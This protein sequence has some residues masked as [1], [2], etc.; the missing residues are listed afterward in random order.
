MRGEEE[1]ACLSAI[2]NALKG[3]PKNQSLICKLRPQKQETVRHIISAKPNPQSSLFP[4]FI[5][6][7]GFIEHFEVTASK[8][9]KKGSELRKEESK[10][11]HF[12]A[13]CFEDFRKEFDQLPPNRMISQ[14][15]E[16][17]FE[18][19]S[20][21]YF[22]VSFQKN[23]QHHIDSLE[24]YD[25]EKKFGIF[26]IENNGATFKQMKDGRYLG[27]LYQLHLDR[28]LLEFMLPFQK[29]IQCVIFRDAQNFEILETERI[30]ELLTKIPKGLYF[31]AGRVIVTNHQIG[32]VL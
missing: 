15:P 21:E 11:E 7:G 23:W 12:S 8:E 27:D 29:Q 25:G 22:F 30:P 24:K 10:F 9:G 28:K 32:V 14:S 18:E 20:Y 16:M 3:I 4:D 31:E 5:F 2:Q 19:S 17:V 1:S 6:D 26:L 13:D